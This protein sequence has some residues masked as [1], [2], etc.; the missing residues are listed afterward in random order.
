MKGGIGLR[1]KRSHRY[2]K[3]KNDL[4]LILKITLICYLTIYGIGYM[5]SDTSAYFSNQSE[6]TQIFT[7]GTWE[8]YGCGEESTIDEVSSDRT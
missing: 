6:V 3:K 1:S 7:A 2:K 8:V 4:F 5:T